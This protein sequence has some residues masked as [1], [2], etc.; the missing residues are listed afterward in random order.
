[1]SQEENIIKLVYEN[2]RI[3]TV[4]LADKYRK[5]FSL[6]EKILVWVICKWE[7]GIL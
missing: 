2:R 1:M 4:D 6:L 5:C 3:K 7:L